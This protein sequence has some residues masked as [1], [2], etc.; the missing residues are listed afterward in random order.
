MITRRVLLGSA[1]AALAIHHARA[2]TPITIAVSSTTLVYGGLR[3]ALGAGL[4]EK[5]GIDLRVTV[6]DSGNAALAAVLG[7]SVAFASAGPGEVLAARMHGRDIVVV[8]NFYRGLLASLMLTKAAVAKTGVAPNAPIEQRL[9]AVDGLTIALPSPT[10]SVLTPYKAA[11]EGVGAKMK[12]AYM[13][14]PATVAALQT[15]AVDG[16]LL[17]PPFSIAARANG[18][19]VIWISGPRNELPADVSP[20]SSVCAQTTSDYAK[21]NPA[22]IAGMRQTA[23]DLGVFLRERPEEA[24]THLMH[25]YPS[26][27]EASAKALLAENAANWSNATLTVEDIKR[28]IALLVRAG[29]LPGVERVDPASVLWP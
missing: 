20:T 24:L 8:V 14:Q 9:R 21:A 22:I 2:A 18:S 3:M 28:E 27:D 16:G 4:Y 26:L 29:G 10:S 17:V 15:G 5:N 1:G 23:K 6:M 19:G 25:A 11:A 7:G 12:Y 13:T